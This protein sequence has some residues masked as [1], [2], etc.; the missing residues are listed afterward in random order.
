MSTTET[1][2]ALEQRLVSAPGS[3]AR[4]VLRQTRVLLKETRGTS[5]VLLVRV[6]DLETQQPDGPRVSLGTVGDNGATETTEALLA[7]QGLLDTPVL[8][9]R[10]IRGCLRDLARDLPRVTQGTQLVLE[11]APEF[12]CRPPVNT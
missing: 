9:L 1:L 4:E 2:E 12:L 11:G 7:L 6:V 3:L 5:Q 10:A 8:N